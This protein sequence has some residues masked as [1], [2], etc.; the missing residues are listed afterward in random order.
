MFST[1]FDVDNIRR[2]YRAPWEVWSKAS[3]G[4]TA[5]REK[6]NSWTVGS[7]GEVESTGQLRV[8]QLDFGIVKKLV[9]RSIASIFPDRAKAPTVLASSR[10]ALPQTKDVFCGNESSM[11]SDQGFLGQLG[12]SAGSNPQ[13]I[14]ESRYY[15][16]GQS[17]YSGRI[18]I[19]KISSA[20]D[21]SADRDEETGW[22]FFGGAL[23]II[24]SS[25][26]YALFK[27]GRK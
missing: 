27:Y 12:L 3:Q 13:R 11:V 8:E 6:T 4:C 26:S 14:S 21:V 20:T 5:R 16:G 25:V 2:S 17:A 18:V 7:C 19:E 10:I 22:V 9:C 15:G 24:F 23:V 1:S